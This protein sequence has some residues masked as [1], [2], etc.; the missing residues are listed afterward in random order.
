MNN[1][2]FVDK[3]K[4]NFS[5]LEDEY[6][7][8]PVKEGNSDIR[9]QTDGVVEYQSDTTAVVIDSETGYAAVWFYR[10]K[11]GRK[12]DLDPITIHEYLN[13]S[14]KDRELLLSSNPKDES[15]AS[16][17]F[18][19]KFLL[20]QP[21]WNPT[22]ETSQDQLELR[23]EN[24]SKWLRKHAN[25]CLQGDFTKWPELYEYKV[26]RARANHIRR[27]KNELEYVQ[28]KDITGNWKLIKQPIFQDELAHVEKLKNEFAE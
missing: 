1:L 4:K 7:F 19:R 5:Y 6:G 17:L 23:L 26:L 21:E 8:K 24:Y 12:F 18:N 27:G 25:L 22:G 15:A 9:K 16:A 28:V 20:N 14:E 2:S 10:I 11:D 3:V 13:T